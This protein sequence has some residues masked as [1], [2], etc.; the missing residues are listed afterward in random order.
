MSIIS[1][2]SLTKQRR[3]TRASSS[4]TSHRLHQSRSVLHRQ[5]VRRITQQLWFS[6]RRVMQRFVAVGRQLQRRC[7]V[8]LLLRGS[9]GR[10]NQGS[11]FDQRALRAMKYLHPFG[12]FGSRITPKHKQLFARYRHDSQCT[13]Q[14]R[15]G[16]GSIF[17][18]LLNFNVARL[19][20]SHTFA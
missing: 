15:N 14:R 1:R 19:Q 9:D 17:N 11:R 20:I 12:T 6:L 8:N 18:R 13:I 4:R 5:H 7:N 10:F 16:F 2:L 3:V